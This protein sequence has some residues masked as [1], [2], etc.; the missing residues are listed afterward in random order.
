MRDTDKPFQAASMPL[1][2]QVAIGVRAR[3]AVSSV[4]SGGSVQTCLL[5]VR[6]VGKDRLVWDN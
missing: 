2:L 3:E 1:A 6:L 4:V 5:Y